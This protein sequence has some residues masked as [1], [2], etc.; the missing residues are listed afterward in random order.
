M[1]LKLDV[2]RYMVII[3]NRRT[4]LDPSFDEEDNMLHNRID[5]LCHV[6]P[7]KLFE[8]TMNATYVCTNSHE[9]Q[10]RIDSK[11]SRSNEGR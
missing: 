1:F 11:V 5:I 7:W 9:D 10:R 4:S 2:F 3:N 8:I 6:D